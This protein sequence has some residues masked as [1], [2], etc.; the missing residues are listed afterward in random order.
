M[1]RMFQSGT[2]GLDT[3]VRHGRIGAGWHSVKELSSDDSGAG[4]LDLVE[5][6]D[7][8]SED[9]SSDD[10]GAEPVWMRPT[11]QRNAWFGNNL[12]QRGL[13]HFVKTRSTQDLHNVPS[14]IDEGTF[15]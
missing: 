12:R 6:S 3:Q 1:A 11:R 2:I 7:S 15:I 14:A 9:K 4:F 13:R 8:S 10:D 5:G